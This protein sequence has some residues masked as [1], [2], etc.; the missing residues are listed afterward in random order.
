MLRLMKRKIDIFMIL[1]LTIS[2]SACSWI[3]NTDN[4]KTNLRDGL[5]PA[6]VNYLNED[7][8]LNNSEREQL[9]NHAF[10]EDYNELCIN[11]VP[12]YINYVKADKSLSKAEKQ[13]YLN[14]A[15]SYLLLNKRFE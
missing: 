13:A 11:V 5:I 15:K 4:A 6:Y 2:V 7:K 8:T 9:I 10:S 14:E 12:R 1:V 3:P